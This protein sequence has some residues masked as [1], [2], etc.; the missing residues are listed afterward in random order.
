MCVSGKSD[1]W[2][3]L[4][5]F[6]FTSP[7]NLVLFICHMNDKAAFS[8]CYILTEIKKNSQRIFENWLLKMLLFQ[9]LCG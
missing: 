9:V 3:Q 1:E 8:F 5:V 7:L 6:C 2:A 4:D